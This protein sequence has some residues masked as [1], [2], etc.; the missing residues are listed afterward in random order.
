[1][2][3][4]LKINRASIDETTRRGYSRFY[5]GMCKT[6]GS[7]FGQ[8]FRATLSSDSVFMVLLADAFTQNGAEEAIVR[9]PLAP[10][11][12]RS[13]VEH[14]STAMVF[15]GAIQILLGDQWLADH[16]MDGQRVPRL[17][18][19]LMG[20]PVSRAQELLK[21]LG[22]DLQVLNGFESHQNTIEAGNPTP[23]EAA[24]PTSSSLG[25][26]FSAVAELPGTIPEIQTEAGRQQLRELGCAVGLVIYL[27][28]ALEDL[29]RDRE[30]N[31][32]NP[33]LDDGAISSVRLRTASRELVAALKRIEVLLKTLP[34][35]RH[36]DI[37]SNILC[38]RLAGR[39]RN[40][41]DVVANNGVFRVSWRSRMT[42]RKPL[43]AAAMF[44]LS[45]FYTLPAMAFGDR[46]RVIDCDC[47]GGTGCAAG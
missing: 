14:D 28:D 26:V 45:L 10:V 43:A 4:T 3:G 24:G 5:C 23:S 1:M 9:C 32:F 2:F 33:L 25:L 34:F 12:Y 29:E 21:D 6:L 19:R 35:Q 15:G 38:D 40:A 20:T 46:I 47:G 41:V 11:R 39:A 13:A 7:E 36:R 16:A 18:R 8:P 44:I 22:V 31:S 37:L 30:E 17:A 42:S 27:T